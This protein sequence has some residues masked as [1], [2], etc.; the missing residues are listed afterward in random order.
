MLQISDSAYLAIAAFV[1]NKQNQENKQYSHQCLIYNI[2]MLENE[3]Y[4][5]FWRFFSMYTSIQENELKSTFNL[6]S[7]VIMSQKYSREINSFQFRK[8]VYRQQSEPVIQFRN[9]FTIALKQV[10]NKLYQIDIQEYSE[11][12]V[13]LFLNTNLKTSDKTTFWQEVTQQIQGKTNKQIQDYYCHS[14]QTVIYD[15][16]LSNQD[17]TI[18]RYLNEFWNYQRPAF[19]AD[20]FLEM[21]NEKDYFKHNIIM[22]IINLAFTFQCYYVF[23]LDIYRNSTLL[24]ASSPILPGVIDLNPNLQVLCAS[25]IQSPVTVTIFDRQYTIIAQ[26][27]VFCQLFPM[28]IQLQPLISKNKTLNQNLLSRAASVS[29]SVSQ[30][31]LYSTE[32]DR[33]R[34]LED[35][36]VLTYLLKFQSL[37]DTRNLYTISIRFYLYNCIYYLLYAQAEE[38]PSNPQA[39]RSRGDQGPFCSRHSE[40]QLQK[41]QISRKIIIKFSKQQYFNEQQYST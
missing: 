37:F 10:L 13:C 18:L 39:L 15:R 7:N 41:S 21:T 25:Q 19:V 11:K 34:I 35:L 38:S 2:L 40:P 24:N 29:F 12:D 1:L 4:D 5:Q 36:S 31:V 22:Y 32:F 33:V 17:K 20:K 27:K 9:V 6:L 14:Y 16:Q 3:P 8:S 30:Q 28:Q 23:E 26:H